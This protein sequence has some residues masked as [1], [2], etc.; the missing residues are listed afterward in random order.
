MKERKI[1]EVFEQDGM[2]LRCVEDDGFNCEDK[3]ALFED[4]Y[5]NCNSV[6]FASERADKKPVHFEQLKLEDTTL[7]QE[8][9]EWWW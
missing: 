5:H 9:P 6:C 4:M 7:N 2:V 3:C 1:G 8:A